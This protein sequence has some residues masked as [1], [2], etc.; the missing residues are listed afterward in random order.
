MI[1]DHTFSNNIYNFQFQNI[2]CSWGAIK[3]YRHILA[4]SSQFV[5]TFAEIIDILCSK[6]RCLHIISFNVK[7]TR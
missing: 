3:Y 6:L 7:L 4:I 2:V 5:S 1:T